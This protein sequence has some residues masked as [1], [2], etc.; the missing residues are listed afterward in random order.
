MGAKIGIE[1]RVAVVEG[2]SRLHGAP[3]VCTDLRGG[4]ALVTAALAAEG[5]T[6]V[7]HIHHI[8]RGYQDFHKNLAA[9]GANIVKR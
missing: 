8:E 4:A 5:I 6:E 2:V 3:V 7:S 9:L 1:G